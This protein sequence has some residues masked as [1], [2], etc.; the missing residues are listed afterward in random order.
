[1]ARI[2]PLIGPNDVSC[3][4]GPQKGASPE[5]VKILRLSGELVSGRTFSSIM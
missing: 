1:M 3:V 4:F 2:N 5:R